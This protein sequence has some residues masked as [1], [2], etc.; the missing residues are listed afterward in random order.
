L[1]L[2]GC[3][4]TIDAMGCQTAITKQIKDSGADYFIAVK[5]TGVN[6]SKMSKTPCVFCNP[7]SQHKELDSGQ[8]RVEICTCPVYTDLSHI[9]QPE[10]WVGLK[11]IVCVESTRYLKA[12]Q[13]K[14]RE[15]RY[16]I[17]GLDADATKVAGAV[18]PRWGLKTH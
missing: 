16:Y 12:S 15:K 17:T 5:V 18:R 2:K 11:A 14:Q 4:V 3:I 8:G 13:S 10:R 1:E 9:Q 6:L 7:V